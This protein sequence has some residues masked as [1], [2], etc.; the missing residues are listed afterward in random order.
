MAPG[1]KLIYYVTGLK[2]IAGI[3]TATSEYFESHERIWSSADPKK[4]AEDYPFR[5]LIEPEIILDESDFVP[6]EPLAHAMEYTK[7]WPPKNWTL[8]FQGNVHNLPAGDYQLI[9]D[10]VERRLTQDSLREAVTAGTT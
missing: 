4:D 6:A 7:R 10:A 8:A 5:V 3:A 1:D 9:R 2:A